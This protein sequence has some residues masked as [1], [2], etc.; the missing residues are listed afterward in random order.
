MS[1]KRYLTNIYYIVFILAI[2]IFLSFISPLYTLYI[3]KNIYKSKEYSK[4]SDY[5]NYKEIRSS[6]APQINT[7]LVNN[8][9]EYKLNNTTLMLSKLMLKPL[10]DRL[11]DS[12]IQPKVIIKVLNIA[13]SQ[14]KKAL[15]NRNANS[16]KVTYKQITRNYSFY[17]TSLNN[18]TFVIKRRTRNKKF[19]IKTRW[20]RYE[21]LKWKLVSIE[22][23][24]DIISLNDYLDLIK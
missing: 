13:D 15:S 24:I 8:L 20:A 17:Y 10:T 19:I 14:N 3:L 12:S 16:T 5:I 7:I 21:L 6:L 23:P 18:F 1:S 4:L 9:S 22:L 2:P 11:L